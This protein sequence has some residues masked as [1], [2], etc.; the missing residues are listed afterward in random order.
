MTKR[1]TGIVLVA[2]AGLL[3]AAC[4]NPAAPESRFA[5]LSIAYVHSAPSGQRDIIDAAICAQHYAP[6]NLRLTTSWGESARLEEAPG[7]A[8]RTEMRVRRGGDYWFSFY[9]IRYCGYGDGLVP[10]AGVSVN[11]VALERFQAAFHFTVAA[12]GRVRR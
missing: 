4:G 10:P 2:A 7:G 3:S 8:M 5:T 11:G 12:D 9:D 1:T 6:A